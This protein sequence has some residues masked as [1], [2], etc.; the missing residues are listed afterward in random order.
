MVYLSLKGDTTVSG[1]I[2]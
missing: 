1:W 2:S